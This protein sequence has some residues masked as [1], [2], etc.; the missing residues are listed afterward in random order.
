MVVV[1]GD[2]ALYP[3]VFRFAAFA[4]A[5]VVAVPFTVTE[6]HDADLLLLELAAENRLILAVASRRHP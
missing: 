2:G 3:E 4:D 5:D 6:A 1:V